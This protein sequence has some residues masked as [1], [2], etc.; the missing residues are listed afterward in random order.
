MTANACNIP[1]SA[2]PGEATTLGNVAV[3]F[4]ASGDIKDL[5]EA[6]NII[7]NSFDVKIYQPEDTKAWDEAYEKYLKL[8]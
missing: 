5:K 7:K 1:V 4:M 2:G 3:Q 6:R 8:I